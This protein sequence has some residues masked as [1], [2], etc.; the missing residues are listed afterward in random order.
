MTKNKYEFNELDRDN[1]WGE[2]RKDSKKKHKHREDSS[3]NWKRNIKLDYN[4]EDDYY[5][6]EEFDKGKVSRW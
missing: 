6:S 2:Y 3:T 5:E 1:D 4:S